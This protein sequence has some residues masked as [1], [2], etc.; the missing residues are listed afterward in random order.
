ML[1]SVGPI[2][3]ALPLLE[4]CCGTGVE[5]L[6]VLPLAML[7]PLFEEHRSTEKD[8][9]YLLGNATGVYEGPVFPLRVAGATGRRPRDGL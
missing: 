2:A 4:G 1:A 9:V 7:L 8:S 3:E 5:E 6:L